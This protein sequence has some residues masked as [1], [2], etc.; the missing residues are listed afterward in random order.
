MSEGSIHVRRDHGLG[1]SEFHPQG[2]I[3]CQFTTGPNATTAEDASVMI[4]DEIL[5]CAIHRDL[6]VETRAPQVLETM[7]LR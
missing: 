4:H 5:P 7:R 2:V 6:G 3:G 1:A